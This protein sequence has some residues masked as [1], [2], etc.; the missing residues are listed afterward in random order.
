MEFSGY[1]QR[2]VSTPYSLQEGYIEIHMYHKVAKMGDENTSFFHAMAI[3]IYIK[4]VFLSLLYQME[5]R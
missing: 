4:I 1:Y 5:R 3:F 2:Q